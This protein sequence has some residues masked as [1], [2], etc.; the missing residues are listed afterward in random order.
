M[1][2]KLFSIN[3]EIQGLK[4]I[5]KI[6]SKLNKFLENTD[7]IMQK[8]GSHLLKAYR[9]NFTS[10]GSRLG[11]P[12]KQLAPATVLDRSRQGFGGAH[13][14]LHRTGRMKRGFKAVIGKNILRIEN[15]T[16]Y[17]RYH[18]IGGGHVPKR[19]MLFFNMRLKKEIIKMFTVMLA[20]SIHGNI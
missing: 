19:V 11:K 15:T 13:P 14:I 20:K 4:K 18:Q 17:Y 7:S 6:F 16:P 2:Q 12:W 5:K 10:E 1:A 9:L 3:V 8:V